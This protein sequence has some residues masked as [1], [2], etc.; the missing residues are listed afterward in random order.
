MTFS[1]VLLF[2]FCAMVVG[3]RVDEVYEVTSTIQLPGE[4]VNATEEDLLPWRHLNG[5]QQEF[6]VRC[7]SQRTQEEDP[8]TVLILAEPDL[9][10]APLICS[11][12]PWQSRSLW[13]AQHIFRE[14]AHGC[15]LDFRA[16][17]YIDT[18]TMGRMTLNDRKSHSVLFI[19][20]STGCNS[21]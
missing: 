12:Y 3:G 7:L 21:V 15:S 20:N 17:R 14:D 6:C 1:F 4:V 18:N 11:P 9:D 10:E 19:L 8:W 16:R 13:V 2:G 5:E